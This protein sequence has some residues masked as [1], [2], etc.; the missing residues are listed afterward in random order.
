LSQL[1]DGFDTDHTTAAGNGM[2]VLGNFFFCCCSAR[3]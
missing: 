1:H 3:S 2:L